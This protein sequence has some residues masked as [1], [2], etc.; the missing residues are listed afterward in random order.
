MKTFEDPKDL[1]LEFRVDAD[2]IVLDRK[3]PFVVSLAGRDMNAGCAATI[4]NRIS[5]QVLKNLFQLELGDRND[6]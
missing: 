1:L 3:H 6:R 4:T 5:D 2:A